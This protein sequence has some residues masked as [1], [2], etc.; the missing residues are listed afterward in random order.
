MVGA[1]CTSVAILDQSPAIP[2]ALL[3]ASALPVWARVPEVKALLSR[4]GDPAS[5]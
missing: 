2:L 4:S 3:V 1:T 5:L